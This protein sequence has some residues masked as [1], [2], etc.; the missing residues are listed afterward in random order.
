[1]CQCSSIRYIYTKKTFIK[2]GVMTSRELVE[3]WS[4]T[5]MRARNSQNKRHIFKAL[6]YSSLVWK[7]KTG[8]FWNTV[9]NYEETATKIFL[10]SFFDERIRNN[11]RITVSEIITSFI[12][13]NLF[14][15]FIDCFTRIMSLKGFT[16]GTGAG[17]FNEIKMK[18]IIHTKKLGFSWKTKFARSR[19]VNIL[20]VLWVSGAL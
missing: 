17:G 8:R 3:A 15:S 7:L 14:Y 2:T 18:L 5:R 12:D 1:M 4:S 19:L 11:L 6:K 10:R 13:P 20:L 16:K 9:A